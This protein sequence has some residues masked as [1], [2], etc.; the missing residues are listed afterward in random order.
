MFVF[1]SCTNNYIPKARVLAS[2]LK[3]FHPDWTFCLLLGETPPDGFVLEDE[4]FDRL[5]TFNQLPIPDYSSWLFRHRVVEICTAAK[6]PALFHFIE[7]EKH[8]KVIYLDPDIMVCNTLDPLEKLLDSHEVLLTPHLLAPQETT[9]SI[10]DNEQSALQ[11]GVFNLGFVAAARRGDGIR[12]ARW[13]RDRLLQYCYDDI[14]SGLFTDQRWCDLVPA[15]FPGLHVVRDPG[16]NAA[17][18][19]L[20]DRTIT[21]AQDGSFL[22]N[23]TPLRFYHFTGFDSGAGDSM[24][25]RYAKDMPAVHELW[26]LYR[27]RLT[28]S[29]HAAL[30]KMRWTHTTFC[31]GT[32]ITDDMRLLYR[33]RE[34]VQQAFPNPFS[35]PGFLDWYLVEQSARSSLSKRARCKLGSICRK[36]AQ[37]LDQHGG[38]PRGLPGMA[39]Q[40]VRW[41]RKWGLLGVARK[42]WHSDPDVTPPIENLPWLRAVLSHPE[43]PAYAS[44]TQLLDPAHAPACIIEHDWGGGADVYCRD[45][46]F[47]LLAEGRAVIRLRYVHNTGRVEM[48]ICHGE[49]ILRCEVDDLRELADSRFPHIETF[50][51]NE[52]AG[53][54]YRHNDLSGTTAR[55]QDAVRAITEAARHHNAHVE[56]LFH[57]YYPVCPTINLL[58]PENSY[59]GLE[60]S[61]ENCNAC[62]LRGAPF[63]MAEWRCTWSDLLGMADDIVFFSEN[64]RDTVSRVYAL[65]PEQVTVRPHALEPLGAKLRIPSDG[66]MRVAVVGNI[67]PHKGANVV[68]SLA[69]LMSEQMPEAS[70][71]V[72]GRLEAHNIPQNITVFGPYKR[73]ELADLLEKNKVTVGFLPSICPE[74]FSLVA[75]ELGSLDLPLVSFSLGAQGAYVSTLPNSRVASPVSAESAFA[76]LLELDVARKTAATIQ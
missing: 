1:T 24:T 33:A 40:T 58:T 10:I 7:R 41:V 65:R 36:T 48:T 18:W 50:I 21:R 15:F 46:I 23:G 64:T 52:F 62:A 38:F 55:V 76:A 66:P 49:N 22:A 72:F 25:A 3:S 19:N 69:R 54:Y 68:V 45:R 56:V 43:S 60:G 17:S 74:T 28:A 39:L 73:D 9:Q 31:D 29:G 34:D 26:A 44:L 47:A 14:P 5:M 4:P 53:W 35:R 2:T 37:I 12:F 75:H 42:I 67:Q 57:D 61:H 6:G 59:C 13:W 27:D 11:H 8:D 32:P 70:I 16:C 30:G 51:V 20:T 71:A 63:S